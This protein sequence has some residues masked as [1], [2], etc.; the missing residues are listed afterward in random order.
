M[1]KELAIKVVIKDIKKIADL[2]KELKELRGEQK[3]QEI[4]SKS[5][6]FQSH[7]NAKAYKARASAI[8]ENSKEL[9]GLNKNMAGA[10]KTT[11]NITK[12][13][14][15]MAKQF[16]KGAAAIGIIVT[17]F[18]MV[19]KVFSS[20]VSTFSE[21]E[22]VMAKVKAVSGA[23]D[24]EF[25]KLT[26]SAEELG[27][28]TFFT[29]AQVGELQLNFSKLGF[30]ADEILDAQQATLDLATATGSDLARAATVAGA[31]VRGFGLDASE[32]ERVVDV[33]AVSFSSSAMS[34]EKWQT[35]MTKVAPI[36]KAAGF[37][38]E[39]TAAIMSKLTDS[40]IEASIA[41]TSLRNILLKM[42]DPTSEL[43]M[44]FGR[45]IHSLDD[46]VPAMKKFIAEGGSMADV[47][48]V[49]DLRQAAA[50][51]QMLTTADGTLDLRDALLAANG[52]GARM[53]E[54]VGDSLQ[55]AWLRLK[56]AIQGVS[57]SLMKDY[58]K[59]LQSV[60]EKTATFLNKLAANTKAIAKVLKI[61]KGFLL[62][63][64][65]YK[66]GLIAAS[67]QL[68][69]YTKLQT[70]ASVS[71]NVFAGAL[72]FANVALTRFMS[73]LVSTGIGAVVVALADLG[74]HMATFNKET[75]RSIN[76]MDKFEGKIKDEEKSVTELK[77]EIEKLERAKKT[78]NKF[79]EEEVKNLKKG[80]YEQRQ[81]GK[82]LLEATRATAT[83]N[84]AFKNNGI[85][86]IDLQTNIEDT[87]IK[88]SELAKQMRNTA[89]VSASAEISKK[90][91]STRLDVERALTDI[92]QKTKD[93]DMSIDNLD[94]WTMAKK[95]EEEGGFENWLR[96]YSTTVGGVVGLSND[97]MKSAEIIEK[98]AEKYGLSIGDIAKFAVFGEEEMQGELNSVNLKVLE[99]I[100][101]FEELTN[102]IN[103]KGDGKKSGIENIKDWAFE[104]KKAL[105]VV[106]KALLDGV[107][108]QEDYARKV[109]D[110][111]KNLLKQE[112][113]SLKVN[114]TNKKKLNDLNSK[115]LSI[116]ISIRKDNQKQELQIAQENF[117][118]KIDLIKSENTINGKLT[119]TGRRQEL[120]AEAILLQEKARIHNEYKDKLLNINSQIA[121]NNLLLHQQTIREISEQASAM[122][123]IGGALQSLAGDNEKLN[124]VKEAGIKI[125]QAASIVQAIL[126]LNTNL[127][128]IADSKGGIAAIFK[129]KAI[130]AETVATGAN[131]TATAAGAAVD[132]ASIVPAVG[133]GAAK[134]TK[135][136]FPFNIIAV[137][138]T[139]ALL[140]KIMSKFEEG[141]I[142]EGG[143]KFANGGMVNGKSHAQGGEKFA[144]GGRVV[145]LEGGEAVINKRSTSMY[146][147]QL[148]AI[149]SAGGGVKFADGGLMN[150]PSFASSQFDAANQEN[151][152]GAINQSSKVI[153][154]EA[155]ITSS[156]NTVGVIEAEATF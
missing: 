67:V 142:V 116:E 49:V 65:L 145:E 96:G 44:R 21:F 118:K 141:G 62:A 51:E 121:A 56:S 146:K 79:S 58:S 124:K 120:E 14:N 127:Q 83:L 10:D 92:I 75:G 5:G 107:V 136:P 95:L 52:E 112:I 18:R 28:T 88:F 37:S 151:M 3:K 147:N 82:S 108:D 131:T 91:V 59:G 126:T 114:V 137:V 57:I 29:A 27:R 123:G 47:M 68:K 63:L 38:I 130:V 9:R 41:G 148:S 152:M 6:Q 143:K 74:F 33:M 66:I 72:T 109:L 42:Q 80:S 54:I 77:F 104:T 12:S 111:R 50:F 102:V 26:E 53:A 105:N 35:S 129:T 110:V 100:P 122:S 71:T 17:A 134:Q 117:Q 45:T 98:V 43:S 60:I 11:K 34:I 61:T 132:A 115:L 69:I 73:L 128:T 149:N 31:A 81:Y 15:G 93:A 106:K 94:I 99:L 155:D 7:E 84:K 144:V 48:E 16:V 76:F 103:G 113:A 24:D 86:L 46:L 40:G 8:K 150:M 64:G 32:T 133:L 2:K 140:S 39:D 125:S 89:I 85:D 36:A 97:W 70:I 23:T 30:T 156:Q 78:L 119:Q 139:L 20:V 55:G 90:I 22:F 101:N 135:L 25:K 87:K 4:R 154:V 138:A 1:T 153:V 13:N 19:S